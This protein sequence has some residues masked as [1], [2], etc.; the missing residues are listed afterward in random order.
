MEHGVRRRRQHLRRVLYY[1]NG[2]SI[3]S[4][5]LL[6]RV[7]SFFDSVLARSYGLHLRLDKCQVLR[8]STPSSSNQI[9]YPTAVQQVG[10]L[11]HST[12]N[13]LQFPVR[14]RSPLLGVG[15]LSAQSS[16]SSAYLTS[17]SAT[18]PLVDVILGSSISSRN[19]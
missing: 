16:S 14:S 8:P 10:V 13:E 11:P 15:L 12:F 1:D 9:L 4:E 5:Q 19:I 2:V 3:G 17:H 18:T 7:L 6:K